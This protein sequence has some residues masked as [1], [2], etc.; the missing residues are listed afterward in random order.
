M[1]PEHEAFVEKDEVV[2]L[3]ALRL[4]DGEGVAVIELVGAFALRRR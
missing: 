2:P 1:F 3:G 4:V